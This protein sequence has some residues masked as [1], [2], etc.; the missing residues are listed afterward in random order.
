MRDCTSSY[1]RVTENFAACSAGSRTPPPPPP[2]VLL[3]EVGLRQG[4]DLRSEEGKVMERE[5]FEY[6]AEENG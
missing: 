2:L 5:V 3:V 6:A 1:G 4:K